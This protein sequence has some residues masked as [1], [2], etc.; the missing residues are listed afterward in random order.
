MYSR[1]PDWALYLGT[2]GESVAYEPF[3]MRWHRVQGHIDGLVLK[4]EGPHRVAHVED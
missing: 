2:P 4:P 1:H 3:I